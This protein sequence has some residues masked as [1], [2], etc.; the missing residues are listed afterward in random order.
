M[1]RNLSVIFISYYK[2]WIKQEGEVTTLFTTS[3]KDFEKE[4][5]IL[6]IQ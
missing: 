5:I 6:F 2:G 3:W 4:Y 1:K